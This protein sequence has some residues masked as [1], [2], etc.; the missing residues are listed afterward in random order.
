MKKIGFG[1]HCIRIIVYA[2]YKRLRIRGQQEGSP[3]SL[4]RFQKSFLI[5]YFHPQGSR[6]VELASR[7]IASDDDINVLAD[8]GGDKSTGGFGGGFG[9]ATAQ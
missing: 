4:Y 2:L 6:F 1:N 3:L 5:P 9:G 7:G 8:A